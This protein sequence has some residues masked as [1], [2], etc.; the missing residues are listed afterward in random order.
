MIGI[1]EEKRLRLKAMLVMELLFAFM[2]PKE[3]AK[4]MKHVIIVPYFSEEEVDRYLRIAQRLYEFREQ[5][6]DYEFLLAAS[7]RIQPSERLYSGLSRVAPCKHFQCPTQIFGYPEGPTAMFW[8]CMDHIHEAYDLDGGFSLWMESDMVPVKRDWISRLSAEWSLSVTPPLLMGCYVPDVEKHRFF[9]RKRLW[10]KEHINGGACYANDFAAAMPPE[11]REG[12]FDMVVFQH[13]E[14]LGRA[15]G[16]R[17]LGFATT[18]S[19]VDQASREGRV[20]LHGFMQDKDAFL[21]QCLLTN[22]DQ[23]DS[24]RA[25]SGFIQQMDDAYE[26]F[27]LRFVVRGRPAMLRALLL[28]QR[29]LEQLQK[30]A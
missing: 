14:A 5:S 20:L 11:A 1:D 25:T 27:M 7:P 17:Q 19:A 29:N 21:E 26:R 10:I 9:R 6:V 4:A 24:A 30:V 18:D 16:T 12:V 13:A 22:P 2:I 3:G 28:K 8:D 23:T 15:I